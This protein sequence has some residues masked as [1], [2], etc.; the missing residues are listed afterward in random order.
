MILGVWKAKRRVNRKM[1]GG[2][3][4]NEV[5]TGE[6]IGAG[7][8]DKGFLPRAGLGAWEGGRGYS[9]ATAEGWGRWGGEVILSCFSG[10]GIHWDVS[11]TFLCPGKTL[12]TGG[13]Y[14]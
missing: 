10:V 12:G 9:T 1:G 2:V 3:T 11:L 4:G 14:H 13:T 6:G 8:G 7:A 5:P